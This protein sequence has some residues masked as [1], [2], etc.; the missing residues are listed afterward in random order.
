[1]NSPPPTFRR[2]CSPLTSAWL[3]ASGSL[4]ARLRQ[5]G[6]VQVLVIRQGTQGLWPQEQE[7]LQGVSGHVREVVLLVD[8]VPAV[9]ARSATPH[10]AVRG[11]WKA[12]A[13]LGSRPLAEILFDD[14]HIV[15]TPLRPIS[16]VRHGPV[17]HGLRNGWPPNDATDAK[18]LPKWGRSSVFIRKGQPLRVFEA[19]A[20]WVLDSNRPIRE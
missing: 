20:P 6:D 10:S 11:G 13:N 15:R 5:L 8:G 17:D 16:I 18:R 14:R 9:W 3:T 4:T 7:A 12:M 19:I 1:M 2:P